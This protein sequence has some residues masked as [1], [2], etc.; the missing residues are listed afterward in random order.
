MEK[1]GGD[2]FMLRVATAPDANHSEL[3]AEYF[4]TYNEIKAL[5][6]REIKALIEEK[7]SRISSLEN[8]IATALQRPSFYAEHLSPSRRFHV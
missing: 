5:A 2:K 4:D 8:M 1:R 6:E 7:D 3:N